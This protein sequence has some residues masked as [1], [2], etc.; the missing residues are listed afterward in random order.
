MFARRVALSVALALSLVTSLRAAEPWP[1][2]RGPSA[3]GLP[4]NQR[5]PSEWGPEQNIFWKVELPG[6]AWSQPIVWGDRIYLTTAVTENQTKP[7][8]GQERGG[9]GD[10]PRGPRPDRP[11][12]PAP[13]AEARGGAPPAE[14]EGGGQRY[15]RPGGQ[16]R[17]APDQVYRWMVMCLD[18]ATGKLLWEKL[19]HEGKPS[20]PIHATNT[21]ASETP[22]TDGERLY[23]YFGMTGLYCFDLD[24]K[25]IWKKDLGSYPM[26]LG[27][28]TGSSPVL[29]GDKLFLQCDNE[30]ESFLVAL[31]KRT[32]EEIW[33]VPREEKST[34]S[35]PYVWHNK[36]RV[37]LV[38]SG[39]RMMRS[40]DPQNGK[41]LWELSGVR[42]RSSA[43]PVGDENLLYLGVGGGPGGLGPLVAVKAGAS[44]QF[45]L[46][47]DGETSEWIAWNVPRSG[48]SMASPLLY[49][50]CLYIFDQNGG[51][52][53]CYDAATGKQHYRQRIEGAKGFTSSPWAFGGKIFALDQDGKTFILAPGPEFKLLGVNALNEGFWSS[54]A[55]LGDRLLLRGVDHLY[56]IGAPGSDKQAATGN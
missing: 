20:F 27:W 34:W 45:D 47:K 37:E 30:S 14:G 4:D 16:N 39:A 22:I 9:R 54:V 8:I 44:G 6:A 5:L 51:I 28:G 31:D 19:A 24:G 12:S 55:I 38:T 3:N 49:E 43:T 33:R 32:G 26:M 53:G 10:R 2:F 15:R 25:E 52:V 56:C 42:G 50:G 21:Y 48:P 23:C 46:P 41:L 18:G 36:D 17:E 35:T 7:P 29:V 13:G 40:Y 11:E 1:Q